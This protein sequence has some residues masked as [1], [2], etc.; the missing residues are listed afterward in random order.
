[1]TMAIWKFV[2]LATGAIAFWDLTQS[3]FVQVAEQTHRLGARISRRALCALPSTSLLKSKRLT[4]PPEH[5]TSRQEMTASAKFPP[6]SRRD[7]MKAIYRYRQERH[8]AKPPAA[9]WPFVSD[10]ARIS[11]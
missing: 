5:I 8:F 4:R 3:T 2:A 10:T 7:R 11:S 6:T 1:M 9:I